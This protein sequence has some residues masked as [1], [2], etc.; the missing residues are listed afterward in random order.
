MA[1]AKRYVPRQEA[2]QIL[3]ST[4]GKFFTVTFKKKDDSIRTINCRLG[5]RRGVKGTGMSFDPTSRKLLPVWEV[6]KGFRMINL[7]RIIDATVGDRQYIF[8]D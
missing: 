2:L 7:A 5:V 1:R 8:C 4:N 3:R 6:K